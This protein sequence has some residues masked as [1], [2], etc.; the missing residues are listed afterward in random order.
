M[1]S[2]CGSTI[3][4]DDR[5]IVVVIVTGGGGRGCSALRAVR[6][7]WW[8]SKGAVKW[9]CVLLYAVKAR[10]LAGAKFFASGAR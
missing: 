4:A 9:Q 8:R 1:D 7:A 2:S 6:H 3:Q 5:I 10:R